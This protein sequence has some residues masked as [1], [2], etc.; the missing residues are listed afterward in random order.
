[1]DELNVLIEDAGNSGDNTPELFFG[2]LNNWSIQN[3]ASFTIDGSGGETTKRYKIIKNGRPLYEN[4]RYAIL[5]ISGTYLVL[6][7]VGLPPTRYAVATLATTADLSAVIAKVNEII[8]ALRNYG[9]LK[10]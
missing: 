1:M 6:G 3:G 10:T 4:N 2:T 9:I 7:E 5:K 8:T